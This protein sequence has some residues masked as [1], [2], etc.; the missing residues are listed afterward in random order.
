MPSLEQQRFGELA[1]EFRGLDNREIVSSADPG[2]PFEDERLSGLKIVDPDR[3][4][5]FG[6]G[7]GKVFFERGCTVEAETLSLRTPGVDIDCCRKGRRYPRYA[8]LRNTGN[9]FRP[10]VARQIKCVVYNRKG[11]CVGIGR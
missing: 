11:P 1:R 2:E 8:N 6:V 7:I 5:A 9:E 3:D 4:P 10:V